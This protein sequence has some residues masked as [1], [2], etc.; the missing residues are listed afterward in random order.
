MVVKSMKMSTGLTELQQVL[1][2]ALLESNVSKDALLVSIS[3][4]FDKFEDDYATE[5][6]IIPDD[7][8]TEERYI[9]MDAGYE[10]KMTNKST[11]ITDTKI[12]SD[13]SFENKSKDDTVDVE[14]DDEE[15]EDDEDEE[16]DY[17]LQSVDSSLDHQVTLK[18]Q[19]LRE[20]PWRVAK[21]IKHYMQQHNIPQREVVDITG[22]N[23][24][25][26]S[27]HLNKGT[28]MKNSKRAMLYAWYERKQKEILTRK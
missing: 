23:Q 28:P 18:D 2:D 20:D 9:D 17:T 13:D 19:L 1:L 25:H 10:D 21:V 12:D 22:L 11:F 26:L 7:F 14:G 6:K 16:D 3:N 27:Q 5:S 15:E 8:K 24:S 4:Y